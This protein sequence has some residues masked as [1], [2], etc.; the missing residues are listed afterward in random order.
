M[1]RRLGSMLALAVIVAATLAAGGPAPQR[2][3]A[4]GGGTPTTLYLH[5]TSPAAT[6]DE[7]AEF[8][9]AGPGPTMDTDPPTETAPKIATSTGAGNLNFR[10]NFL[11]AYW[12]GA[13]SGVIEEPTVSFWVLAPGALTIEVSLFGDGGIGAA[14]PMA[15][16]TVD[17]IAAVPTRVDV[18]F[19]GLVTP[20]ENEIVLNI[21]ARTAEDEQ[22]PAQ[23][24]FDSTEFPSGMSFDLLPLIGT[25][26]ALDDPAGVAYRGADLI[27]AN[28][29][30]GDLVR[31]DG[32]RPAEV[33]ASGVVAGGFTRGVGGVAVDGNG[34]IFY[35][36]A[37]LGEIRFAGA[38]G[39]VYARGLGV[40]AGIAFDSAGTLYVADRAGKRL[41]AVATDGSWTTLASLPDVPAGVAIG[42]GGEV[43]V[44]VGGAAKRIVAVDP[45]TGGVTTVV[46]TGTD[47]PE[48]IAVGASGAVY[49]GSGSTGRVIRVASGP[50]L[51]TVATD[52]GGPINLAFS[53]AGELIVATQGEG[54]TGGDAILAIDAGEGGAPLAAPAL[55][56]SS[57]PDP[58]RGWLYRAGGIGLDPAEAGSI[59]QTELR[60]T[61]GNAFEPTIGVQSDGDIFFV[62]GDFDQAGG[63]LGSPLLVRSRNNGR[64]W[65]QI[66]TKD[67][68]GEDAPP[69]TLDPYVWVDPATDRVYSFDLTVACQY[70]SFTDDDG[71]T[72]TTNP[73]ACGVPPIDHQ[74][75]V[76]GSP[77]VVTTNG[78]PNVLYHCSNWVAQSPCARSRDGGLSW[79]PA[80]SAYVGT[81]VAS[82]AQESDGMEFEDRADYLAGSGQCGGLHGHAI[83]DPDGRV[84]VPKG[85]CG[86]PYL[87]ISDDDGATWTQVL[88]SGEVLST[89]TQTTVASDEAGNLY[90]VW[91]G[92]NRLPYLATST[93][94]GMTWSAPKMIGPPG[95]VEANIPSVEAGAPG[96]VAISFLGSSSDYGY[97]ARAYGKAAFHGYIVTMTDALAADPLIAATTVSDLTDP[98]FRGACGPGRCQGAFDFLDIVI[99]GDGRAWATF[100]DGCVDLCARVRSASSTEARGA[101][102]PLLSGPNL[103]GGGT[104][105]P[106]P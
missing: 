45:G 21:A 18:A 16:R 79:E 106:L 29:G 19:D 31:I 62:G 52:V 25:L 74:T 100:V 61:G 82:R 91:I 77:R 14:S 22:A 27:A 81:D 94:R 71:E 44:A 87:S 43:L 1:R 2:A 84:F 54:R 98:L 40:P 60:F 10:K 6:L 9:G 48:G 49:V 58:G 42:L 7:A 101:V 105:P 28:A 55:T 41:L 36:V 32:G 95:L 8:S 47:V 97:A 15:V 37:D 103:R 11:N 73:I 85:H 51:Q 92:R 80:G 26:P 24:M 39:G 67:P 64:D 5:G 12:G 20:I 66:Q 99:D 83:T 50:T 3:L 86:R 4:E 72:W 70:L 46:A 30:T 96:S 57:Q 93:D 34:T 88:V 13:I 17:V 104:L 56:P 78:Y 23:I 75:I 102:A 33:L 76:G 35:G 90:Y 65:T 59:P 89:G 38:T 53:P 68:R 69:L 63:V